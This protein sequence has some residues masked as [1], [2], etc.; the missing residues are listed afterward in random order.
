[1]KLQ[2]KLL[3]V[4]ALCALSIMPAMGQMPGMSKDGKM[5]SKSAK[6]KTQAN[7]MAIC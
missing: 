7:K 6:V 5:P 3:A 1:M 2:L 4:F